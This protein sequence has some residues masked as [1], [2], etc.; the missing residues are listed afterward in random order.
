MRQRET[1]AP[2]EREET[3]ASAN[4]AMPELSSSAQDLTLRFRRRL[5]AIVRRGLG[6]QR[7]DCC[8]IRVR[9]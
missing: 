1:P 6:Q 5:Q 7:T 3:V 8:V 4:L 9:P 2:R